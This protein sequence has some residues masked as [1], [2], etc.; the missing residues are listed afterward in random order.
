MNLQTV[1]TNIASAL[2]AIDGLRCYW[3][4][5]DNPQVPFVLVKPESCNL[6]D[7][8]G[9]NDACTITLSLVVCVSAANDRTGQAA[10]DAYLSTE[11]TSSISATLLADPDASGALTSITPVSWQSY[12]QVELADG[13][14][15]FGAE[16]TVEVLT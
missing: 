13:T 10:L 1:R 4:H 6:R 3:W 16:M 15:W 7:L 5:A 9:D 14:R 8:F 2:G 12:G 11:G